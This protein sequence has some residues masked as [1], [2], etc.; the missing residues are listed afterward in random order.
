M[1]DD[2]EKKIIHYLQG[3]LPLTTRP[4]AVLAEKIGIHEEEL[5]DR[6]KLLKEQGILRR[7]GA[8]LYHQRVGFKANAMVA[9]YVPDDKIEE[10][11]L[12]MATFKEVSHCYQRKIEEKWRYNLFTMIHGKSKKDCQ[13]ICEKIAEKT[14]IKDYVSLLTLKEYKKTSPQYF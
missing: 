3:D 10:T 12:L 14:G 6:I 7:L 2:L 8:T 5:L 4:F 13:S 11:G 9:W 1:L